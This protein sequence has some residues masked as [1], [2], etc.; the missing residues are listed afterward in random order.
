M[1]KWE[2]FL[3]L[4]RNVF[5]KVIADIDGAILSSAVSFLNKYIEETK[6]GISSIKSL[7]FPYNMKMNENVHILQLNA[8][9]SCKHEKVK[10][11]D[12]TVSFS[13]D[14]LYSSSSVVA[15]YFLHCWNQ[16]DN[17]SNMVVEKRGRTWIS[18]TYSYV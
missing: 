18:E 5:H 4:F 14:N 17:N 1:D 10:E 11:T 6:I 3:L 8:E 7:G 16:H 9:D 15:L 12:Y 13:C 2:R